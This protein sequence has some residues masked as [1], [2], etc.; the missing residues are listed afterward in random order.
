MKLHTNHKSLK[1]FLGVELCLDLCQKVGELQ[2]QLR[3]ILP[4]VHWI[5]PESIHLTLK[6][7]GNVDTV[8]VERVLT[9]LEPLRKSQPPFTLEIQGLG[10]FPHIRRPRILWIGCTGDISALLKLVFEI[11]GV[12]NP[13]G[14]PPEEKPYYPHLT[15]ARIKHDNSRVGDV[16]THSGLL[17]Q[18]QNF[19]TLRVDRITF[20]RS[21]VSQ[22]GAE[23][24]ALGTVAFNRVGSS[25]SI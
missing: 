24:T 12:L 14:F 11:E 19:G 10:V 22:F 23:Y 5:C 21:D 13:L 8:M 9:A 18:P 7:L 1:V 16:L 3:N 15:L 17:E 25:S 4:N 20:F 2:H 6:F